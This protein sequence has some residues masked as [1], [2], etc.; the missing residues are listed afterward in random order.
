MAYNLRWS[1]EA[2]KNLEQILNYL[3]ENWSQ[4]EVDN[5]KKRFKKQVTLIRQFPQMFP[6][7][8]YNQKLRKSLLSKQT[9][10]FF[11]IKD[12]TIM[13]VY[14]FNTYQDIDKIK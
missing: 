12:D 5:F 11:E 6:A 1:E 2:V 3:S 7:S 10:I 13:L 8:S 14:I 4:K 9:T